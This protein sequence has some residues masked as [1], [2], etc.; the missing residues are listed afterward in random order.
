MCHTNINELSMHCK[1]LFVA[2]LM[3]FKC[4]IFARALRQLHGAR[5]Y[6][7][8]ASCHYIPINISLVNI[9]M[10]ISFGSIRSGLAQTWGP[11]PGTV[12]VQ[13]HWLLLLR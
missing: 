11:R 9:R 2:G 6:G 8:C 1:I 7:A 5:G 3:F 12:L 13:I 4:M 10:S